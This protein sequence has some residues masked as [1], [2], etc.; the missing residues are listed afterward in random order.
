MTKS[1]E[2]PSFGVQTKEAFFTNRID[3]KQMGE[4]KRTGRLTY[5]INFTAAE[6]EPLKPGHRFEVV[7]GH[8]EIRIVEIVEVQQVS[9]GSNKWT[10]TIKLVDK[11]K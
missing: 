4:L 10:G 8:G 7:D 3:P 9:E 1:A 11:E 2:Q 6:N 5:E